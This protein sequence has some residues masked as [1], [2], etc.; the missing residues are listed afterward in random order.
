MTSPSEL[1]PGER[2]LRSWVAR[3][4]GGSAGRPI[5][6]ELVLT[7][8]RLLFVAKAGRFARSSPSANDRS[9]PLEGVGSA[10][11]HR[12]E[13]RIGYG[14]RMIL[15]GIQVDGV[16]Y[17]LGRGVPTRLHSRKSGRKRTSCEDPEPWSGRYA[18]SEHRWSS[19]MAPPTRIPSTASSSHC[20][21]R[22][23]NR[24]LSSS[25][26]AA[27]NPGGSGTPG[28]SSSRR[29]VRSSAQREGG[30]PG[31]PPTLPRLIPPG[32]GSAPCGELP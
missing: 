24:G 11:P 9:V 23:W 21:G 3:C 14:D 16:R 10:A 18:G 4:S 17:E 20:F 7:N 31:S 6:G 22:A 2:Q 15:E 12:T 5:S 1:P 19:F 29:F 13:M 25:S 8:R 32:R 28:I 30:P 27:M 26:V